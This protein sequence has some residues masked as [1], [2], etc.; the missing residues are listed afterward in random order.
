[1]NKA[2]G[3]FGLLIV[4]CL[5]TAIL[6]P[7]FLGE[8]NLYNS[9]RWTAEFGIISIGVVFV[10]VTGGIDL[11]I[12][13]LIA[14]AGTI[15]AWLLQK[16]G[17]DPAPTI[18]LILCLSATL[19]LTHGL[20]ITKMRLQP[21][22]VT[23]CGLLVYRGIARYI[24]GTESLQW[25]ANKFD[26]LREIALGKPFSI[27]M[28][29]IKW[30]SE[31]NWGSEKWNYI[32][33][34]PA[35]NEAGQTIPLDFI[36]WIPMPMPMIILIVLAALAGIFLNKTIYGRYLIALGNNEEAARYSGINTDRMKLIAYTICGLMGGIGG[37]VFTLEL[38]AVQPASMGNFYELYAIAAAV[39]GGCSLRGGEASILGV[40]IA[41]ALIRIILN[42][43]NILGIPS[44]LDFA[45]VG[46]VL[47]L[48]VS[49]DE[50][51]KRYAVRRRTIRQQS[52][53]EAGKS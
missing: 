44:D 7:L 27:P 33:N 8:T 23:L 34:Q 13:S 49:G 11:S 43:T 37:I 19:G 6:N 12:G 36:G 10:I 53:G 42:A 31:G 41:A 14:L 24:A 9:M 17:W 35:L 26:S 48:G 32:T 50:I 4:V 52:E 3:V 16:S 28:P 40:F 20:L 38:P 22:V 25:E 29:F 2:T 15:M 5:I 30:I 18:A 51:F 21:F 1:M 46:A 45:V 39:L 47:L